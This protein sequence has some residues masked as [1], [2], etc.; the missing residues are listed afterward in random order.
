MTLPLLMAH[1][2]LLL[3]FKHYILEVLGEKKL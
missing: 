2:F 3:H 1:L